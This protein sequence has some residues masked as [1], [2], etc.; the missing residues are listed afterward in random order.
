M[1]GQLAN[2]LVGEHIVFCNPFFKLKSLSA[3]PQQ[4]VGIDM[5]PLDD[6]DVV[7]LEK[8]QPGEMLHELIHRVIETP[9][10]SRCLPAGL[11]LKTTNRLRR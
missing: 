6:D 5:A 1:T 9:G 8:T 4:Q 11:L 10:P 7:A 2:L 3:I